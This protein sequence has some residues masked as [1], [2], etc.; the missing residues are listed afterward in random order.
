MDFTDFTAGKNDNDRR[1]DKILRF[2]IKDASLS[3]IYKALRKGIIKL[4]K[5]KCKPETHVFEGDIISIAS[6]LLSKADKDGSIVKFNSD[7]STTTLNIIFENENLLV[8]NKPYDINVHGD[9][10]SLDKLVVDYYKSKKIS[11]SLSFIPGPLHR[12]DK[13]TTGLLAFSFSLDGARWF[14]D[15]IKN[16]SI[17]KIYYSVLE[18][19]ITKPE[20]WEDVITNK[21]E[22]NNGFHKVSVSTETIDKDSRNAVTKVYPLGYGSW[23]NIKLTFVKIQILTGRKHQIRAQSSLHK[24]PLLGDTVYGGHEL[25]NSKQSHFL[26]A[27]FLNIPENSLGIPSILKADLPQNFNKFLNSCGITKIEL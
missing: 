7:F 19:E 18:G 27:G 25:K 8:I 24:H 16:H 5:K 26:H 21:N 4:N 15:N 17:T 11:T 20:T 23:N 12:L 9:S 1:M 14:A 10:E 3:E 22:E 13:K 2:F 6:F